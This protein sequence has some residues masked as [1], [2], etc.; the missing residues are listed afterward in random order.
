MTSTT[1]MDL[2]NFLRQFPVE[3]TT[4]LATTF[5]SLGWLARNLFQLLIE[6]RRY[7][8]ELKT[9][10]WKEKISA[11]KKAS[12]YYLETLNFFDL[13]RIQ[14]NL[15]ETSSIQH[16]KLIENIE[17]EV[18]FYREK[19]KMFPHFEHHHINIFYDF[20]ERKTAEITAK[21]FE[22]Q[23][24]IFDLVEDNELTTDVLEQKFKE[25]SALIKDNYSDLHKIYKDYVREVRQ[26]IA[27]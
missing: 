26:D 22:I 15:Y 8:K 16:E 10:F 25:Y 19:L 4:L 21:T 18:T 13:V 5:A 17:R 14:F 23:Q 2:S 24:K 27:K 9:Y 11:A 20:D 1:T 12:E 6:N 7:N 3:A